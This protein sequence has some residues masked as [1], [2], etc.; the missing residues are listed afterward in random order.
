MRAV[1]ERE[2]VMPRDPKLEH[3][4]RSEEPSNWSTSLVFAT[5][6]LLTALMFVLAKK[7]AT[8]GLPQGD[9][10]TDIRAKR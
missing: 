10:M 4:V 3:R 8:E 9:A 5:L 1:L 2:S 6:I 7:I